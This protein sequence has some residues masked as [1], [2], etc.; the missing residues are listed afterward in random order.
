M[1]SFVYQDFPYP[2]PEELVA[3]QRRVWELIAAPGSW[4]NAAERVAIAQQARTARLHRA[5][6][7]LLGPALSK[8]G[9]TLPE[10]ALGAAR[11]IA[12]EPQR[13]DSGWAGEQIAKLGDAAYIELVA[14]TVCICAIDAFADALGVPLEDLPPPKP[15]EPDHIRPDGVTAAGAYVSMQQPWRGP[16]VARA[17]SL[18]P[19]QNAMFMALVMQMYGGKNDFFELVW[20]NGPLSRPQVELL[21]ARVSAL[22]ECFY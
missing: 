19:S 22:N 10:A 7:E 9:D 3:A 13:I 15:G 6:L 16:N 14:V 21:A 4:W 1:P 2:V 12:A 18:V 17:L 11:K 5:D 8:P 20:E